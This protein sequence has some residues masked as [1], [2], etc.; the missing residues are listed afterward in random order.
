MGLSRLPSKPPGRA[1]RDRDQS[2]VPNPLI[3]SAP[4]PRL[5][6]G[7]AAALLGLFDRGPAR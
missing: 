6:T 3:R 4:E 5:A 2:A 1:H 7:V